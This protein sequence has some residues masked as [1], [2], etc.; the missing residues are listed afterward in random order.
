MVN[1]QSVCGPALNLLSFGAVSIV[2][3]VVMRREKRR[4]VSD[5][6]FVVIILRRFF[7]RL[8][9]EHG[10]VDL[11]RWQTIERFG[12]CAIGQLQR[13]VQRLPLNELRR[14]GAGRDRAAAAKGF[15]FHVVDNLIVANLQIDLHDVAA[16]WVANLADA[17]R[18]LDHANIAW[19]TEMIHYFFT[20]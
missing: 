2:G 3:I 18:I 9:S 14:H 15:K 5:A 19:I 13:F 16:G 20:V 1:A 10:A 4:I 7:D 11:V 6:V 17:V 8:L 12:D